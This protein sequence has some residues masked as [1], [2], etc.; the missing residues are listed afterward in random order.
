METIKSLLDAVKKAKA[1][2]SDYALAKA[3]NIPKQR[4]SGYYNG[5]EAPNEY[6][7]LQIAEAL[8]RNLEEIIILVQMETA[9]DEKRREKWREYYKSIGGYAASIALLFLTVNLIVTST[10][11]EASI[12]KA[13]TTEDFVLCKVS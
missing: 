7:C 13:S 6:V 5:K 8:G 3:L 11:A 2:E 9:K 10:P 12:G 1:I 4:I